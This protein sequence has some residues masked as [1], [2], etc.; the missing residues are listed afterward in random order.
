MQQDPPNHREEQTS[1]SSPDASKGRPHPGDSQF[2]MTAVK[3]W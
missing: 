2:E 1:A 3:E